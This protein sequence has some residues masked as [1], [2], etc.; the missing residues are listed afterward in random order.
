MLRISSCRIFHLHETS[1]FEFAGFQLFWF[2]LAMFQNDGF[3]GFGE[4][5]IS[6][7]NEGWLKRTWKAGFNSYRGGGNGCGPSSKVSTARTKR[8]SSMS[9]IMS[10]ATTFWVPNPSLEFQ[11]TQWIECIIRIQIN[12]NQSLFPLLF[13]FNFLN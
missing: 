3:W 11:F 2:S 7:N 12:L 10:P 8:G 5:L 4:R 1:H 6:L 13:F 9:H